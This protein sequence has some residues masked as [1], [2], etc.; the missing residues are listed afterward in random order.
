LAQ[1]VRT[2]A[3]PRLL[4]FVTTIQVETRTSRSESAFLPLLSHWLD[5]LDELNT[6]LPE[7]LLFTPSEEWPPSIY[8]K[9]AK[10][11]EKE[12]K[13]KKEYVTKILTKKI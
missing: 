2:R 1:I 12:K 10:E 9:M 4:D 13:G 6:A 5:I 7:L 11:R 8:E 3:S